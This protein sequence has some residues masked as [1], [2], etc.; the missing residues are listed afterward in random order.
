MRGP[1]VPAADLSGRFVILGIGDSVMM[2]LG[3]PEERTFLRAMERRLRVRRPDVACLNAGVSGVNL[4]GAIERCRRLDATEVRPRMVLHQIIPDDFLLYEEERKAANL[5]G[6]GLLKE[7]AKRWGYATYAL[8]KETAERSRVRREFG[9]SAETYDSYIATIYRDRTADLEASRSEILAFRDACRGRGVRLV[10]L[11]FPAWI[12]A[13]TYPLAPYHR[14]WRTWLEENG[15][16]CIDV[17]EL[18]PEGNFASMRA[19]PADL[20]HPGADASERIG[21]RLAVEIDRLLE[22]DG[23]A[24]EGET[25]PAAPAETG[26]PPS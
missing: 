6:L 12:G 10:Y 19:G 13:E 1:D 22:A 26:R 21:E 15:I 24:P 16:D 14:L 4:V 3:V 8:V 17:A 11:L 20:V 2:G 9:A 25:G 5:P 7:A 18:L 23:R